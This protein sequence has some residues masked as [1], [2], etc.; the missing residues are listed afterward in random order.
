MFATT[1]QWMIAYI[2]PGSEDLSEDPLEDPRQ[3]L[4][5]QANKQMRGGSLV[6]DAKIP[7]RRIA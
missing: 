1:N 3:L 6:D 2:I 5:S 7:S 4:S